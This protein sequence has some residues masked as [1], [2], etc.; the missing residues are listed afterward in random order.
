MFGTL[1]RRWVQTYCIVKSHTHKV[2]VRVEDEDEILYKISHFN[3]LLSEAGVSPNVLIH[4]SWI[5]V[6]RSRDSEG[7]TRRLR[8]RKRFPAVTLVISVI[9]LDNITFLLHP[10]SCF[11]PAALRPTRQFPYQLA[12]WHSP[13]AKCVFLVS[14]HGRSTPKSRRNFKVTLKDRAAVFPVSVRPLWTLFTL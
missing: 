14:A 10:R 13:P 3:R 6:R 8:L 9:R 4:D 2:S 12:C 5:H 1:E 11:S 7:I